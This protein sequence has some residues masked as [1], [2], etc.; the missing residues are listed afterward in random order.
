MSFWTNFEL[1][2]KNAAKAAE[3]EIL[4]IAHQIKPLVV[5][6]AEELATVALNAVVNEAPKVISGQEKLN[7]AVTTVITG[8]AAQGKTIAI[9]TAE[10]AVQSA[11]NTISTQLSVNK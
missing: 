2:I 5:A 3:A 11:Y 1:A 8:L 9:S 6:S 10:A 4:K 7:Q